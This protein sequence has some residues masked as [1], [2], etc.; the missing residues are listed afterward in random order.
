MYEL[1]KYQNVD[2]YL[3][4]LNSINHIINN[5]VDIDDFADKI[6]NNIILR[7]DQETSLF[8]IF[9][10]E[11]QTFKIITGDKVAEI[12]SKNLLN[13]EMDKIKGSL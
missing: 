1:E 5:I 8:M 6:F 12:F 13:E 7:H 2:S 9:S 10:I 11:D 4:I 3:F